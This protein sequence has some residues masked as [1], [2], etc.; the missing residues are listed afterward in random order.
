YEQSYHV[1][2]NNLLVTLKLVDWLRVADWRPAVVVFA[3]SSEA[4]AGAVTLGVAPVP[5][6]EDVPLV[7]VNPRNPRWSYGGSKLADEL[8]ALNGLRDVGIPPLL[9]RYHNVY[10][11]R[12]GFDHVVSEFCLRAARRETPF[13]VFGAEQTRTYC[14]VDD[15]V[16]ATVRL[17]AS[18]EAYGLT[19]NVGAPGPEVTAL[20]LA[21]ELFDL[22][23]WHPPVEL[24]PAPAGSVERRCPNLGLLTQLVGFTPLHDL[25]TGLA[26]TY[27]WH[28]ARYA[29][30]LRG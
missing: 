19:V 8:I 27:E 5:T 24:H 11:P 3:S 15:A 6:P 17:A 10:G 23:G 4:Y 1:L 18:P 26:T 7:V 21:Q 14:Y 20:E 22:I 2:R 28:E 16:D 12:M 29:P 9:A 30:A 13:R 25:R